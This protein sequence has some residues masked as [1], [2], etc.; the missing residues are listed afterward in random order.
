LGY[1]PTT[2]RARA[3]RASP[4]LATLTLT[5][6]A[7]TSAPPPPTHFGRWGPI[8]PI[9]EPERSV[10]L[11]AVAALS[12]GHADSI[13]L[14]RYAG[15]R[16]RRLDLAPLA[17]DAPVAVDVADRLAPIDTGAPEYRHRVFEYDF[18][19]KTTIL[20]LSVPAVRG[21][22]ASLTA[23]HW[24]GPEWK[25]ALPG[26][27]ETVTL[28]RVDGSW[29]VTGRTPRPGSVRL[30]KDCVAAA[31]TRA[32]HAAPAAHAAS[33][34]PRAEEERP[35]D[36]AR[37]EK[38]AVGYTAAWCSKDPTRVASFFAEDGSLRI[39]GGAPAVGRQ[40]IASV[41]RDFMTAFPDLVVTMDQ[42]APN[43]NG[44]VYRWTLYG[45]NNGPGGTGRRVQISGYEEW[46]LGA[47]GLIAHSLGHFD[48]AEYRHQV[49]GQ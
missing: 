28:R 12:A 16:D 26:T 35:M 33:H 39:N 7:C 45:T 17:D 31:A 9:G 10:A 8:A 23:W 42:V 49:S 11:A 40:A 19:K 18:P 6:C 47:D 37:V 1:D 34:A 5:V 25:C 44:F 2:L 46:T 38:L 48:E 29:A 3:P 41:A 27:S 43:G 4:L 20:E 36:A 32:P 24:S 30:E 14:A 13:V 15:D 21:D 22:A